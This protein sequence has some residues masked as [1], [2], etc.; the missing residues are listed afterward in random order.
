MPVLLNVARLWTLVFAANLV[1]TLLFALA[2]A[3]FPVID[4]HAQDALRDLSRGAV[5]PSF[6]TLLV[7]GVFAG[8]LV[9]L[10]VWLLPFA[11]T[12]RVLVIAFITYIIAL[13][14]LNHVIAGAGEVFYAAAVGDIAWTS[15]AGRYLLASLIGNTVGGVALVAAIKH[16]QFS[17][18]GE[19]VDV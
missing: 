14:G 18:S 10:M 13:A 16:A 17:G 8:W 19:T 2:V 12:A 3:H 4:S 6:T 1:G 15:G 7:R 9:A 5:A 11:E